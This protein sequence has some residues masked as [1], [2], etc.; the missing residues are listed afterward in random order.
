MP[1]R[2]SARLFALFV[3]LCLVAIA[4]IGLTEMARARSL[5]PAPSIQPYLDR[6]RSRVSEFTLANGMKF[7]VLQRDTAPVIS[8]VTYAEVGSADEVEGKTGAAHYLEHLAF[9]GTQQIGTKNY[10]AEQ[11]VLARLDEVFARLQ[12]AESAGKTEEVEQLQ[13][14]FERLQ[15]QAE[16]YI[17]SNQFGRIVET[18]GG[19]GLNAGTST[20]Y[21]VYFYSFPANKLELWMSLE[22][23]RFLEPVF[24][25]F[26]KEKQV[27]L[28]ERRL[29]TDNSPVGTMVEALLETAF[30]NHPYEHPVIG[31][32]DDLR[33]MRREDIREF[34]E[35]HYVPSKLTI[36]VVGDIEPADV[37]R[38]AEVYFGRF[39]ARATVAAPPEAAPQQ[40]QAEREVTLR[41][42]SQPW[43]FEGYHRPAID[44]PD[45]AIY[46]LLVSI[47]IDGRTSRLYQTLVQ[48]EQVALSVNGSSS[49][50]G[51]RFS[52]LLL[53]YALSAPDRSLD[54]VA[55]ALH[56]EL[57]RL[58]AEPV[59]DRE[60]MRVK[61]Q[62]RARILRALKSNQGMARLLAEYEAKTGDWRNLFGELDAIA[63]V[64]P[65]DIQR[66]ARDTFQVENRTV[67]RLLPP[68]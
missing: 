54:E 9:K 14:Q 6:V 61:K 63:A 19:V 38:L 45:R 12:A 49:F 35:T 16:E 17:T 31:Y 20:D 50:P 26:Y 21:T 34:F 7:I 68:E 53:F 40:Q 64:T 5:P 15:R 57:D 56:R 47:L 18:N 44:D 30:E 62:A 43:Y 25:E 48:Q 13:A 11:E 22:S 55:D 52:S 60:L 1:R 41:F 29:R 51:D 66:V 36:A 10:A 39:E 46:D 4:S 24:R 37:K 59:S 67:G 58:Q 27:V 8:F 23:E 3:A 2:F 32:E 33:D 65:A 28:E 42:P